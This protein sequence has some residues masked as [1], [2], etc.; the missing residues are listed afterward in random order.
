MSVLTQ[1]NLLPYRQY[2]E[3][4]VVNIFALEGTGQNGLLVS[5]VTGAQDPATS[6]GTYAG[7]VGVGAT[8][9]NTTSLRHLVTR[10]VKPAAA[11]D[12]QV[13]ILGVTLHTVAEVDE[14]GNKLVLQPFDRTYERGYVQSGQAVPILKRGIITVKKSQITG[15]PIPGYA[16][17][18]A[19][20]GTFGVL[21]PATLV[22]EVGT[23]IKIVGKWLSTTGDQFGGYAQMHINL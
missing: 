11:T 6:A 21:N 4:E 14:N 13:N 22:D 10:R 15:T 2:P 17:I 5:F 23:G 7:Q 12:N 20:N 1:G 18:P 9:T 3:A 19:A 8:F 16:V